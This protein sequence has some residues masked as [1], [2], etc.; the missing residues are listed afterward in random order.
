MKKM[1]VVILGLFIISCG[2]SGQET[3]EENT[4]IE[5]KRNESNAQFIFDNGM[6]KFNAYKSFSE[7]DNNKNEYRDI[8][9]DKFEKVIFEYSNTTFSDSAKIYLDSIEIYEGN[10]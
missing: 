5:D 1:L 8:A 3:T 2:N 6:I 4:D 10:R 9:K 7:D